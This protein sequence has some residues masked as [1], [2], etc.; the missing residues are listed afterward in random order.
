MQSRNSLACAHPFTQNL[1]CG[2]VL[3]PPLPLRP[4][5]VYQNRIQRVLQLGEAEVEVH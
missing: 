3:V 5:L 4:A 1:S 2:L